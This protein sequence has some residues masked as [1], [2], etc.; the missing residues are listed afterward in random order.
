MNT[1]N[2]DWWKRLTTAGRI[3]VILSVIINI[4]IFIS[5]STKSPGITPITNIEGPT[6]ITVIE[7][8]AGLAALQISAFAIF[9]FGLVILISVAVKR[10]MQGL[11]GEETG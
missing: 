11:R 4:V 6:T 3:M 5:S 10:F 2:T 8:N 7:Y 1:N 9:L